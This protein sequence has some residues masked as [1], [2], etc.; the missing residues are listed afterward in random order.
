MT[1]EFDSR[2][3]A[4][5]AVAL[6]AG[7]VEASAEGRKLSTGHKRLLLTALSGGPDSTA[8]ALLTEQYARQRDILHRTIIVDHG[9]RSNSG[10]EA[11]RVALRMQRFGIDTV[12]RRVQA[13]APT[14]GIQNWARA[15]RYAILTS[16]A[17]EMGAFLLL[18]QLLERSATCFLHVLGGIPLKQRFLGLHVLR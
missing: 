14:G 17:H 16:V 18:A 9:L 7:L 2:Q 11:R 5:F 12:I 10:R 3:I 8:L 6:E 13:T 15:Q 4:R 1:V